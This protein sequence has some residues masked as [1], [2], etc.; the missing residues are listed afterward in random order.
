MDAKQ[1]LTVEELAELIF[2]RLKFQ[3]TAGKRLARMMQEEFGGN[4]DDDPNNVQARNMLNESLSML[5]AE[6][7]LHGTRETELFSQ[8]DFARIVPFINN[9][10]KQTDGREPD[11]RAL[12]LCESYAK[13]ALENMHLAIRAA[14]PG[15]NP[16]DEHWRWIHAILAIADEHSVPAVEVFNREDWRDEITRRTYTKEGFLSAATNS[17]DKLLN[18]D[19]MADLLL[20]PLIQVLSDETDAALLRQEF[21]ETILPELRIGMDKIRICA[22]IILRE[23][24]ERIFRS[25]PAN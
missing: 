14:I 8:D 17:H 5:L 25:N 15:A 6:R 12:A 18:A 19:A 23:D 1:A 21:E 20:E 7:L 9:F 13:K 3:E 22:D 2:C 24:V 11:E 16:Y 4:P 10:L